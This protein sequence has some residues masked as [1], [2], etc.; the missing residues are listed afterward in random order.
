M[1]LLIFWGANAKERKIESPDFRFPEIGI[2][3]KLSVDQTK[4][5]GFL[6]RQGLKN[7]SFNGTMVNNFIAPV[8]T[9]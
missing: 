1:R 4:W 6:A 5:T 7:V 2:S 3:A 8:I 9:F